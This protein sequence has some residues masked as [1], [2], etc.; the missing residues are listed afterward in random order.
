M[1]L[2]QDKTTMAM[3]ATQQQHRCPPMAQ[4]IGVSQPLSTTRVLS[5]KVTVCSVDVSN[6]LN[7]TEQQQDAHDMKEQRSEAQVARR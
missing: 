2:L 3:G 1:P 5:T 4:L 7:D 6:E